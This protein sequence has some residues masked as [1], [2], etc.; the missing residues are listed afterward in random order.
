MNERRRTSVHLRL[1][2]LTLL[3]AACVA[4]A[5]AQDAVTLSAEAGLGGLVRP[6]RWVP[7]RI[8]IDNRGPD[9]SGDLIADWGPARVV[10]AV[11]LAS[12]SLHQIELYVRTSDVRDVVTVRLHADGRDVRT[13]DVPVRVVG[14]QD[15]V[16]VVLAEAELP[17]SWRGYDAADTVVVDADAGALSPDR[18]DALELW[19]A[20]RR[21]QAADG[22]GPSTG[23]VPPPAG[24]SSARR[25]LVAYVIALCALWV[26]WG[27]MRA[28]V[29]GGPRI[30]AAL[31]AGLV[32]V[33]SAAA[34]DAGA[35]S[36]AGVYHASSLEQFEDAS[37]ARLTMRAV[38]QS[39]IDRAIAMRPAAGDGALLAPSARGSEPAYFDADGYPLLAGRLGLGG[40]Q[41]FTFEAAGPIEIL[42]VDRTA[43]AIRVTNVSSL[44]LFDCAFPLAFSAGRRRELAP[45]ESIE[46]SAPLTSSDPAITCRLDAAVITFDEPA[47]LWTTTGTTQ[48]VYHLAPAEGTGDPR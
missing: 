48:V 21:V 42:A 7:V 20:I 22:I 19:R 13:L 9:L 43:G 34:F 3:T 8:T 25:V 44:P 37:H 24:D 6:G 17:R 39:P 28:G 14:D 40:T 29:A 38:A 47:R 16:A 41:P 2:A 33:G 45:G 46:T 30:R 26:A 31:C 4:P 11:R 27:R 15:P 10:R 32:A 23:A 18:R 12:P 5:R 36:P 1:C 35:R